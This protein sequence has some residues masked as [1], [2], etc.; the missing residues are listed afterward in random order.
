[1]VTFS[2]PRLTIPLNECADPTIGAPAAGASGPL[3]FGF[4][5]LVRF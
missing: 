3:L 5:A 4:A 1:M 2:L